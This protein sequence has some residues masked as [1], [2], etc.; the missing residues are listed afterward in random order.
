MHDTEMPTRRA[1][2]SGDGFR[3][4]ADVIVCPNCGGD[5]FYIFLISS[6]HNHLQCTKCD[7]SFCD[8]SC[9][10]LQ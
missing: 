4:E 3:A 6:K 7:E 2:V 10:G 5:S 1:I 9:A 8:G